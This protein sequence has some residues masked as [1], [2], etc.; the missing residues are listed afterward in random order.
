MRRTWAPAKILLVTARGREQTTPWTLENLAEFV[1]AT[2][3]RPGRVERANAGVLVASPVP[4]PNGYFNAAFPFDQ[5]ERTRFLDE[6]E[7]F[8]ADQKSPF[9]LWAPETF[10]DLIE[11]AEARSSGAA[12]D[13]SPQMVIRTTPPA[14]STLTIRE[15]GL[16]AD[17]TLFA[18]LCEAGYQTPGLAWILDRHDAFGAPGT[19][20]AVAFDGE[21]PL[22]VG[23]GFVSGE[24]GGVFYV[25]TPPATARRGAAAAITTW[26]TAEL[27]AR[28]A[29]LVTLQASDQGLPVY[30][31]LGFKEQVRLRRFTFEAAS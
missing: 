24:T 11:A 5:A 4:V 12:P 16:D 22:G 15:V 14:R 30:E 9:V 19:T 17:S 3:G 31:R 10:P 1:A 27:F 23:C 7:A 28:D 25:A 29:K 21:E 18:Q 20:W 26:L 6:A 2:A 13:S 8:F